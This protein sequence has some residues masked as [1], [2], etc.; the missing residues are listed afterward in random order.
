MRLLSDKQLEQLSKYEEQVV[1]AEAFEPNEL[2]TAPVRDHAVLAELARRCEPVFADG[3]RTRWRLRD[4][5]RRQALQRIALR[6]ADLPTQTVPPNGFGMWME[7]LLLGERV[8]LDHLTLED[9]PPLSTALRFVGEFLPGAESARIAGVIERASEQRA[10]AMVLPVGLVGRH[11][12]LDR[13]RDWTLADH[14]ESLR[15]ALVTGIGGSGKSALLA[16]FLSRLTASDDCATIL[17]DFDGPHLQS[18]TTERLTIEFARQLSRHF[19]EYR[20]ELMRFVKCVE[21]LAGSVEG[22]R[23]YRQSSRQ[24]QAIAAMWEQECARVPFGT[25][26]VVVVLDTIEEVVIRGEVEIIT[27]VKWVNFLVFMLGVRRLSVLASG[28]VVPERHFREAYEKAISSLVVGDLPFNDAIELLRRQAPKLSQPVAGELVRR[29]GGNPLMLRLLGRLLREHDDPL[30]DD[31]V[32]RPLAHGFLYDRILKRMRTDDPLVKRLAH[33]GLVLRRTTPALIRDVLAHSLG[34][35]EIDDGRAR[36]LFDE[37][38]RH[39]WLVEPGPTS[40]II[41]HRKDLRRLMLKLM[42]QDP[43]LTSTLATVHQTAAQFYADGGG[44]LDTRAAQIEQAYHEA[45]INMPYHTRARAMELLRSMGEDVDCLPIAHATAL[46]RQA[47][48]DLSEAEMESLSFDDRTKEI[49]RKRSRLESVE[50]SSNIP[51]EALEGLY[52]PSYASHAFASGDWSELRLHGRDYLRNHFRSRDSQPAPSLIDSVLWKVAVANA[53]PLVDVD[54]KSSLVEV[55]KEINEVAGSSVY[56]LSSSSKLLVQDVIAAVGGLLNGGRYSRFKAEWKWPHTLR[57]VD[58]LRL[59]RFL[60]LSA[61]ERRASRNELVVAPFLF[62]Y[63]ERP[64]MTLSRPDD[65]VV[66]W[67]N[68]ASDVIADEPYLSTFERLGKFDLMPLHACSRGALG[69]PIMPELYPVCRAAL[70]KLPFMVFIEITEKFART[71]RRWP[72]DLQGASLEKRL[73]F[74]IDRTLTV[75]LELADR[76]G[77]VPELLQDAVRYH[78]EPNVLYFAL[79][80]WRQ[81]EKRLNAFSLSA[82]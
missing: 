14:N 46:R 66:F 75:L 24:E 80:V 4:P 59:W 78:D 71:D 3:R 12:E 50:P 70:R 19:T 18:P 51:D 41:I 44:A 54:H 55:L 49:D 2:V 42:Q 56:A 76:F 53:L 1:F 77:W 27:V 63:F 69:R 26:R 31:E 6:S 45:F 81:Y 35:G 23:N 20:T 60:P 67:R 28:R 38:A 22:A 33:P 52:A 21:D 34:F 7:K 74:D 43:D 64:R 11:V 16:E 73:H 13:L 37:L 8:E 65:Q 10:Q 82:H 57:S 79:H 15:I 25:K 30:N 61:N 29:H 48:V 40:D 58:E 17:L 47:G 5:H 62:R 32:R 9:L 68:Q 39:V 72:R 36:K